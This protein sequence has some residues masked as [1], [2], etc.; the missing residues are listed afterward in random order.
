MAQMNSVWRPLQRTHFCREQRTA[1]THSRNAHGI[2]ASQRKP[3]KPPSN[4]IAHD[5]KILFLYIQ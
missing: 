2:I 4:R 3:A 5:T 1:P